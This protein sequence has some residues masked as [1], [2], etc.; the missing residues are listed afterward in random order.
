MNIGVDFDGTI[1]QQMPGHKKKLTPLMLIPGARESLMGLKSEGHNLLLM[2]RR[3]NLA[4]RLDPYRDPLLRAGVVPYPED[5]NPRLAEARFQQM[6]QFAASELAG[7][8]DAVDEGL[9]GR[10]DVD[11]FIDDSTVRFRT[12]SQALTEVRQM[13]GK[14][15]MKKRTEPREQQQQ[16]R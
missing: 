5:F 1:V 9:Q 15:E 13:V 2:S 11:Y 4:R 16:G 8:I 12:W 14:E 7:I 6:V 3:A 10:P